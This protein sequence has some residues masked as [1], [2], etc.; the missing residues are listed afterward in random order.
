MARLPYQSTNNGLELAAVLPLPTVAEALGDW[1]SRRGPLYRRLADSLDAAIEAG[2]LPVGTMLPPERHLA[3]ALTVSRSTVVAAF[4]ALKR[5]GRL[6]ARQGSGTWVRGHSRPPDEGNRELVEELE[7]H[8]ILRD[9]SGAPTQTVEFTAA[10]VDCA[11]EV[12]DT[13]A[14]LTHEEAARW[15]TGHGYSPQGYEELRDIIAGRLTRIGLPT[16]AGQVLIT[17]GATQG[18]LLAA[19]LYLEPG[20]PAV[21]ET[22]SYAGAIDVLHAAGARLLSIDMDASGAR[23]DQLGELMARSLPRLVY[24]VPDFHNPTGVVLSQ[25]RRREIAQLAAEFH[26]PV[27]EDLVQRELWL[28]EP[29]PPP[30][31]TFNPEAPVLT[32]GSMSKVFWGGLR[33][34]WIRASETTVARLARLKAVDDFGTPAIAQLISAKLLPRIDTTAQWRR[35]DLRTR[36][37]VLEDAVARHLPQWRC[38]RPAGGL[39]AWAQLPTPRAEEL[40]RRAEAYGVALVPGST[41]AVD[42]HR[43]ADRIRLPFVAAPDVIEEGVR[44]LAEA[45]ADLDERVSTPAPHSVVV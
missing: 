9:L 25:R 7:G 36:Y 18:V 24:L 33:V 22:P 15:S 31:A 23:T 5:S 12:V 26:V 30:I 37:A 42:H 16:T 13:I 20:A 40:V 44:R 4:E 41:F 14:S 38:D 3:T 28:D 35:A 34:G 8:A 11:P 21:L 39:S 32:I 6:E 10:A 2:R 43:H 17:S 45:W 27:V 19:R 1:S 29:P